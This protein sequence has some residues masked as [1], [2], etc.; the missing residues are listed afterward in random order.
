M[1]QAKRDVRIVMVDD[2][3]DDLFLT[4]VCFRQASFPVEFVSLSSAEK[5]HEYIKDN[6][7]GAIDILLL[8]LNMPVTGGVETLEAL[9]NYPHFDELNVFM[10]STSSSETD[11]AACLA[12]GAKGY[13]LKPSGLSQMR[14][15]V[16]A[17]A[18]SLDVK[19]LSMAS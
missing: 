1:S 9:Q 17:V 4:G 14:T 19:E 16:E 13:L 2:D 6:G 10:F 15:F 5:L 12:A 3:K 18:L 8:D 7:I 11:Q